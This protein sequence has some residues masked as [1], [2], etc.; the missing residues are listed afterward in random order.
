M[1]V[2]GVTVLRRNGDLSE[3]KSIMVNS[4]KM[5]ADKLVFNS[6]IKKAYEN[7][8]WVVEINDD[9]CIYKTVIWNRRVNGKGHEL[10]CDTKLDTLCHLWN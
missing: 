8:W 2:I 1:I 9:H 4:V 10:I 7:P 6:L 5:K 3:E